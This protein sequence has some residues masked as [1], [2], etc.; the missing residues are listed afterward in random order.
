M[1]AASTGAAPPRLPIASSAR[2]DLRNSSNLVGLDYRAEAHA[3]GP[4]IV[5]IVDAHLHLVGTV[6]VE[7]WAEAADLYGIERCWSMTPLPM[8]E[9]VR[10]R[11]GARVEFIAVPNWQDGDRR[12][13][14]GRGYC[15]TIERFH[16]LG[17]RIVKFWA[18]PRGLDIG[19]EIGEPDL[20]RLDAP[21]RREAMGLAT[22]L[23]MGIMAHVADPDTWF[24]TRYADASLYGTKTSHYEPLRRMLD[25]FPVPWIVAHCGGSPEDLDR[26]DALLAAHSNLH[27]DVSATKWM[28]REL[29][30]HPRERLVAFFDRWRMRLLFGSDIVTHDDHLRGGEGKTEIAAKASDRESAF[31]LY[32]SRY[33][34]YRAMLETTWSGRSPIAD[35]DLAAVDPANFG[36]LDAPPLRGLGLGRDLLTALYRTNAERWLA[37]LGAGGPSSAAASRQVSGAASGGAPA[38][39]ATSA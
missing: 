1:S 4:A 5:P 13:E 14:H 15:D 29:S 9:P 2:G 8:V 19:R 28:V 33:W 16:A 11:L 25:E 3:L 30:R 12:H 7:V 23:G 26:L 27:L 6:A 38:T 37:S 35:P 39:S 36:P 10:E 20:L 21:A 32:A 18:A 31:D 24:A 22:R 17:S 34:A